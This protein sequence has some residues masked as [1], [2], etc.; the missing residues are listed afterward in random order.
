MNV[1]KISKKM[2]RRSCSLRKKSSVIPLEMILQILPLICDYHQS[3]LALLYNIWANPWS[4]SELLLN[5]LKDSSLKTLYWPHNVTRILNMYNLPGAQF[6]LESEPVSKPFFKQFVKTKIRSHHMSI[7][8]DSIMK[9]N[10]YRFIYKGDFSYA[11]KK[12]HPIISSATT[13]RQT[14][15]Q[16]LSI[17]HMVMEY[18]NHQNC[19]WQHWAQKIC[20]VEFLNFFCY[21]SGQVWG[22]DMSEV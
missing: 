10:M 9:S 8:E 22:K 6:I 2:I 3:V 5:L 1:F 18:P 11:W 7:S 15:V 17:M 16:K 19:N 21:L 14:L 13:R 12:P 4:C 20:P